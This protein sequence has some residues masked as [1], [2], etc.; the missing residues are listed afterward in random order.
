LISELFFLITGL[1]PSDE[2]DFETMNLLS[3]FTPGSSPSFKIVSSSTFTQEITKNGSSAPLRN[4]ILPPH[5]LL[6]LSYRPH[7]NTVLNLLSTKRIKTSD[8]LRTRETASA[9]DD[10]SAPNQALNTTNNNLGIDAFASLIL[11]STIT[12]L[13]PSLSRYYQVWPTVEPNQ[14][15]SM[16]F[17][18]SGGSISVCMNGAFIEDNPNVVLWDT[19]VGLSKEEQVTI[20]FSKHLA[21]VH[22]LVSV[23]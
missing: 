4:R 1:T 9:R 13:Q 3:E 18:V 8:N 17:I 20:S 7:D 14:Q 15:H 21:S 11:S 2:L 23:K 10:E 6:S 16:V 19:S 22:Q 12:Y 5:F